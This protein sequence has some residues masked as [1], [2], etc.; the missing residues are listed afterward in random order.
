MKSFL[1]Y[2]LTARSNR[3]AAFQLLSLSLMVTILGLMSRSEQAQSADTQA[4]VNE[5]FNDLGPAIAELRQE[6]GEG[7]REIVQANMLLTDS[8]RGRFWPLYDAYRAALRSVDDRKVRLITDYAAE[9]DTMS[10]DDAKRLTREFFAVEREKC[11]SRK[12]T[13]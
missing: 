2:F 10:E 13:F 11:R 4:V 5:K 8:E 1:V 3:F 6:V 9:R 12:S 7:R